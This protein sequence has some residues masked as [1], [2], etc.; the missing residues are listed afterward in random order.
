[1]HKEKFNPSINIF[2]N[3]LDK[4]FQVQYHEWKMPSIRMQVRI[5]SLLTAFL[6]LIAYQVDL[7]IAPQNVMP[8]MKAFHLYIVPIV[9]VTISI[10]SFYPRCYDKMMY[11]LISAPVIASIGNFLIVTKLESYS[12]Y[13][14]E[15]YLSIFWTLTISGL[16]LVHAMI[17]VVCIVILAVIALYE[18]PEEI[19]LMHLFWILAV[20]LFGLFSAYIFERLNKKIFIDKIKLEKLAVTDNLTGLFNRMKFDE[21]MQNEIVRSKR[22]EHTFGFL[23]IDIDHFK[24]VNDAYGHQIGDVVL[25]GIADIIKENIRSTDLLFR[26]GGEEFVVICLEANKNGVLNLAE[27]IRLKIQEHIFNKV[28]SK[29]VSIGVSLFEQNDESFSVIKKADKALYRAK[30]SGRNRVEIQ[31]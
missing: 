15:F 30:S 28:G 18:A 4:N 21:I 14:V 31:E 16:R 13:T 9:L 29:T 23:M 7:V 2:L 3:F 25:K 19:Y 6:Y 20:V 26:W 8:L 22:F 11:I 10:L 5:I 24:N 1:M 17:S 27:N 12:V